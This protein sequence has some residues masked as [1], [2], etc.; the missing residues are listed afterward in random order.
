MNKINSTNLL[1]YTFLTKE[2]ANNIFIFISDYMGGEIY[3]VTTNLRHLLEG[4]INEKLLP[5]EYS[6]YMWVHKE[7]HSG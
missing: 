4:D 6:L 5:G 2:E 1:E 7:V 3:E